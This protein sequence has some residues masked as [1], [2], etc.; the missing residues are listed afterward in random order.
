[1][2][3]LLSACASSANAVSDFELQGDL[4]SRLMLA[5][6]CCMVVVSAGCAPR[7]VQL[8]AP[9]PDHRTALDCA[10]N[11]ANARG[12]IPVEGGIDA[13][14][15]H[16]TRKVGSGRKVAEEAVARAFTFGLGGANSIDLDRLVIVGAAGN[17][18]ITAWAVRENGKLDDPRD[19]AVADARAILAACT[20]SADPARS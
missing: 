4:M 19:E 2:I 17:L 10:L 9:A 13:G 12:Y 7:S 18:R 3:G 16:M 1:M 11:E 20:G 5:A 15:I 8:V 14:Q 6:V